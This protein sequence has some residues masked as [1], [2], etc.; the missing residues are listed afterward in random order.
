MSDVGVIQTKFLHLQ[1]TVLSEAAKKKK[2]EDAAEA[3]AGAGSA[4]GAQGHKNYFSTKFEKR[5]LLLYSVLQQVMQVKTRVGEENMGLSLSRKII[6]QELAGVFSHKV[7]PACTFTTESSLHKSGPR[8]C[9]R[10]QT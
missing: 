2:G 1:L 5:G 9:E 7:C 3:G 10:I 4:V 6:K 8:V